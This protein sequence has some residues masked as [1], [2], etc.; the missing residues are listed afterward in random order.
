MEKLAFSY[1]DF[2]FGD[3]FQ[4]RILCE[5]Y[6]VLVLIYKKSYARKM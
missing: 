3:V 5:D 1:G 4:R 6:E 2:L